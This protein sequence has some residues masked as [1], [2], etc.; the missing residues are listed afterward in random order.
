[1][2]VPILRDDIQKN[3]VISDNRLCCR[4]GSK[5]TRVSFI[6]GYDITNRLDHREMNLMI[7]EVAQ[8]RLWV[9]SPLNSIYKQKWG[10]ALPFEPTFSK[11]FDD[12]VRSILCPS[13][14]LNSD[15][16]D[17]S[18]AAKYVPEEQASVLEGIHQIDDL[19]DLSQ[20]VRRQW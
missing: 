8:R 1:T 20:R 12:S 2:Y 7:R 15:S 11:Y 13:I 16:Y 5:L 18:I 14:L 19:I 10:M 6:H 9:E 17:L 3:L 4:V